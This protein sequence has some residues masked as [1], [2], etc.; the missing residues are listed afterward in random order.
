MGIRSVPMAEPI[1]EL[2]Q[3]WKQN[4]SPSATIALCDALRGSA[5]APLIQQVGEFATQRHAADVTVL[6]SVARMYLD[7][8]RFGDAQGVLVAAGKQAPRDGN[9]YRW[10]GEVLLR[11]GDADRAEKVIERAIQL[12]A[13]DPDAQLW[14][15]RARVFRP[16]QAKAGARA[17]AAEVAHATAQPMRP[18]LDSMSDSTTAVHVRPI[19]GSNPDVEDVPDDEP[20]RAGPAPPIPAAGT[21]PPRAMPPRFP[22]DVATAPHAF[23]PPSPAPMR[24]ASSRPP[25]MRAP[26][27]SAS[28]EIEI[29]VQQPLPTAPPIPQRRGA[30]FENY[31]PEP[32]NG[33]GAAAP[34]P[35]VPLP[36]YRKPA[37][38]P[39]VP[40][41]RDVLD[42]LALAGVFEPPTDRGAAAT[43]AW[44]AAL[45]G[46]KRKG[47][48]TL[49]TA[50]ILFLGASVGVYFFYRH[51][52]ALEHV[53]AEALLDTVETQLHGGKPADLPE[54]EKELAQAFQ[55]DSRNPRAA[56][57][58]TRERALVGLVKSGAD[59]AFEDAMARAKDVGVP[60]EK[61][62]FARVASFLLQGDTAGA[63][64]VLTKMDG[65]AG[66][67]PWYQMVAGATLERAGDARARDRYATAAKL[68][69]ALVVAQI[70]QAR[71]TATDGDAQEGM[72]LAQALRKS[73]PDRAEPVALVALAWGRDP[74]RESIPAPPEVDEVGKRAE[75]LPLGL[76]FVSHA[77][78]ALRAI[79]KHNADDA[80]AEIIKG[81]AVAESPGA[82]VWLGTI[83]LPLGDEALAR[84]A[85]LGALQLS[86]VYEPAR[87]LAARV[88][89]LGD[90]LDE[91]LKATEDLEPT[92]PDVAVV[93]A[94]CSYERVD[95]DG[96][97][98]ALEALAPEARKL[99][100][101][102]SLDLAADALSGKLQLDAG[103]L[104]TMAAD[105]APWSDVIAMDTALGQGDLATADKIAASWGKDAENSPLRALR[106]ARL[107]RYENRLDAADAL[108]QTALGHGTVTPRILWERAYTLV[109]KNRAAEVGPLLAHYPLVLG[110]LAT[111]LSAYATASAG[112]TEGAKGRTASVDPPPATA[113]LEARVVAAVAL[114]AMKD[115]R[116]GADYVKEVLSTGSQ[117]PD[118]VAAALSLGF[119]KVEHGK[120]PPTYE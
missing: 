59:V 79:D 112:N 62:A 119:H 104:T 37:D 103:K 50:M 52:R 82:A 24:V 87:A 71:S 35:Y 27:P 113:P 76:K 109:A 19:Q 64:A 98:R 65:P 49:S 14:L 117:N 25:P 67:D 110:P 94:A 20:T 60:E 11:R 100:F 6:V 22:K 28:G 26:S 55:L 56:L 99:P 90:R 32:S 102:Q 29:S 39:M 80:R 47:Y 81:L 78:A 51:K 41:P 96:V 54:A 18:P 46:P 30:P 114:S 63:A 97:V 53:Q 75:E 83:A 3:R 77:I 48:W 107:A 42:A 4:P 115:K 57:D 16:M 118:L 108:S 44:A 105:D 74:N 23:E 2:V 61:Y 101:L 95:A 116:R 12:G 93:R 31:A 36:P 68:D 5:R 73:M 43:A 72:R 8:H 92:S 15:E 58:W 34:S 1:D 91:A 38:S 89:L 21:P 13:R 40:H 88:A 9:I 120:R 86:A 84:K 70:A 17:V 45:K 106:L 111:W 10:L 33:A 7:A 85:A 69:P 66:I